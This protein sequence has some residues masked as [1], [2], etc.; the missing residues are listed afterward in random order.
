MTHDYFHKYSFYFPVQIRIRFSR[1]IEMLIFIHCPEMF[2]RR[3]W[4]KIVAAF[5]KQQTLRLIKVRPFEWIM[6]VQYT[7]YLCLLSTFFIL[8]TH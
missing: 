4:K 3:Q 8:K 6:Y 2:S 7:F 1:F 5:G